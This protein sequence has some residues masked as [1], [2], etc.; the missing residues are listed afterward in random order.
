MPKQFWSHPGEVCGESLR[1]SDLGQRGSAREAPEDLR[2][3]LIRRRA[4]IV[5]GDSD[6]GRGPTARSH[7]ERRARQ[8]GLTDA[9]LADQDDDSRVAV[10]ARFKAIE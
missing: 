2:P 4:G 5:R 1:V 3:A 10:Q 8:G 9:G 6:G 7:F